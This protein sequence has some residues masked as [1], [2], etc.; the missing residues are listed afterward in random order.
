MRRRLKSYEEV[1]REDTVLYLLGASPDLKK[2]LQRESGTKIENPRGSWKV[3]DVG[4]I[5]SLAE[6]EF[7]LEEQMSN[8]SEPLRKRFAQAL[9]GLEV[10]HARKVIRECNEASGGIEKNTEEF[11]RLVHKR[12]KSWMHFNLFVTLRESEDAPLHKHEAKSIGLHLHLCKNDVKLQYPMPRAKTLT[13]YLTVL[14]V[15]GLPLL[16]D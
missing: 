3:Q 8:F 2:S 9:L 15:M 16:Y 12:K 7:H 10:R 11:F 14:E 13:N 6:W 5:P 4:V 1:Q